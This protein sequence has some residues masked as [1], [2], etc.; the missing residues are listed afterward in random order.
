MKTVFSST[1][2]WST[3]T[4]FCLNYIGSIAVW[5]IISALPDNG[6]WKLKFLIYIVYVLGTFILTGA[7]SCK[8]KG[9]PLNLKTEELE[10]FKKNDSLF[11]ETLS[12][13]INKICE[14]VNGES[15]RETIY[16]L[17]SIKDVISFAQ[18]DVS[19]F[20]N[21]ASSKQKSSSCDQANILSN[22]E[23]PENS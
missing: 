15:D 3:I 23:S 22:F 10:L 6:Y 4:N 14:Q 13:H 8:D 12:L 21:R 9:T 16:H 18:G 2:S 20:V 5:E 7:I 1:I 19:E 17:I 11:R